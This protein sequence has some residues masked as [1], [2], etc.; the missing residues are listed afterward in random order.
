[1]EK[2]LEILKEFKTQIETCPDD[3]WFELEQVNEA[4]SELEE[5]HELA[6]SIRMLCDDRGGYIA[7]L[8]EAMKPK[9]CEG[10][11]TLPFILTELTKNNGGK[12]GICKRY[13]K[14]NYEAESKDNV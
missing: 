5:Y 11:K 13:L 7:E 12:C 4:I 3:C 6:E 1:M 9:T 2:A 10:C 8:E 14:D